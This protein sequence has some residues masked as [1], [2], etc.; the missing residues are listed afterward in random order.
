M[1]K[2]ISLFSIIAMAGICLMFTSC[3]DDDTEE[4]MYLS[5]QWQGDWGMYYGYI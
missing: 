4:A 5:G 1:K 2:A 3:T